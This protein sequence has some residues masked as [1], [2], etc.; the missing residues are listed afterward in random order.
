[1]ARAGK[2]SFNGLNFRKPRM[3]AS[4]I[5]YR[6]KIARL[7]ARHA[8][9]LLERAID[10]DDFDIVFPTRAGRGPDLTRELG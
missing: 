7:E 4:I 2:N 6:N 9:R 1:M 10:P 5:R 3:K 8:V